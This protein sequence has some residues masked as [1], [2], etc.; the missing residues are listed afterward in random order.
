MLGVSQ[1]TYNHLVQSVTHIV[2][3]AW[4]MSL[5]PPFRLY[6]PQFKVF[7]NL[8]DFATKIVDTRPA[9][10][11]LGFHFI[12]SL[13]V[14]ANYPLWEGNPIVSEG[15][16]TVETV[17]P[18]G[19]ADAK[20]VGEHMLGRTL[21]RHPARFHPTVVRIAQISGSTRNGY[22]NL[23][24]YM[25]FLVKSLL[26]VLQVLPRLDG[27]LSWYPVDLVA[28]TL[29]EL[30]IAET[31]TE[32][33]YHIESSARQPWAEMII[34]PARALELGVDCTVPYQES[35]D[36]VRRFRGSIND[37]PALHLEG[38]FVHFF[39]PMS[40]GGPVLDAAKDEGAL[41]AHAGDWPSEQ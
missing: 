4:P 23:T 39:I 18:T 15:P 13:A 27:T 35:L 3:S 38:F 25:P 24:E 16:T 14:V 40:C 41:K 21:Q 8:M 11:K 32:L 36:R 12:S 7:R 28:A 33:V 9:L 10:F 34:S 5:T 2:H 29:G 30:L 26:A 37:N 6:D 1:D 22:W 17:P 19:Y 20:L 31:A